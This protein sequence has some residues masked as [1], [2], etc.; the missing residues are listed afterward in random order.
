MSHESAKSDRW[1]G[2]LGIGM[3]I[4]ILVSVVTP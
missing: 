2:C 4:L 1:L 3:I